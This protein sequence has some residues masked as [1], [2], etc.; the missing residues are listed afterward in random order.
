MERQEKIAGDGATA[1]ETERANGKGLKNERHKWIP[2]LEYILEYILKNEESE[3][4]TR[5]LEELSDRLR[6]AGLK[7][8]YAVNTPYINSIPAGQEPQY[9]GNR[10]IERRIKSY[11]RWNAMA[12]VV[13]A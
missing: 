11:V 7:I 6:E 2:S 9:P 10:E 5:L 4:A 13:K 3:Q 12:M 8:P 1:A